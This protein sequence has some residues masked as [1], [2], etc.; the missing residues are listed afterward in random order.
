MQRLRHAF[1][2]RKIRRHHE[3]SGVAGTGARPQCRPRHSRHSG[4]TAPAR[5]YRCA[6]GDRNHQPG[7]R[8]GRLPHRQRRRPHDRHARLLAL[9]AL[10]LHENARKHRLQTAGQARRGHWPQQYRGQAH[11]IDAAR[12]RRHRHH[13]PQPHA[14]FGRHHAASRCDRGRRGQT[15]CA[16]GRYGQARRRGAGCGHEP[17]RRRPT[18]WRCGL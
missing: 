6:E 16:H 10:W 8:C 14:R 18:V 13:L 15:Q 9:H 2:T 1:G 7:Q 11:G 17:Q 12:A 3:R 5:T 4:A